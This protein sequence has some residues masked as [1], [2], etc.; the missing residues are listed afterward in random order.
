MPISSRNPVRVTATTGYT[1]TASYTVPTNS[2]GSDQIKIFAECVAGVYVKYT[3][4]A[5]ETNNTLTWKI[6]FSANDGTDWVQERVDTVSSST[7]TSSVLEHTLLAADTTP[8]Y[9]FYAIPVTAKNMRIQV[10]ESGVAA[11]AGSVLIYVVVGDAGAEAYNRNITTFSVSLDE[12]S[13]AG[14]ISADNQAAPTTTQVYSHGM[15]FDGT[16]WDRMRGGVTTNSTT[17]TG[18]VNTIGAICYNASPTA[19]TEGQFG[20]LQGDTAGN[21]NVNLGTLLAGEDQT[22]GVM[23]VEHRYTYTRVTADTQIKAS[24]GFVHSIS[25]APTTATPTAGLLTVY[26]NTAESGTIIYSEWVFATTVGHTI[27]L[28]VPAG[29]GIYVGYDAT[30]ANAS[31]TVAWR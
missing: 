29:T 18:F 16:D 27:L 17:P 11:N 28:D 21:L 9:D 2:L 15:V 6:E 1:L 3:A 22:V 30:L 8:V 5:A 26:D 4:G 12:F 10:K 24:A 20:P 14:A 7:V 25:I 19:R 31:C 23:K 13:T